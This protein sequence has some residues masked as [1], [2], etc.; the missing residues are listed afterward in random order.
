[1]SSPSLSDKIV[2]IHG[3][4]KDQLD[5]IFSEESKI[6]VTA[7]AGCGKTKSMVSKI[8][9]EIVNSKGK[10]FKRILALTF[11]VNAAI[12][13][14]DDTS[15]ILPDLLGNNDFNLNRKLDISNYHGFAKKLIN[16]HGYV[17]SEYLKT[18]DEFEIVDDTFSG[19]SSFMIDSEIREIQLLK[20][21]LIQANYA[22][23]DKGIGRYFE[24]TMEKLVSKKVI[25]YD[26]MLVI[27]I[28]LL[29]IDTIKSFYSKYY[30]M[31]IVDEFQDTNYLSYK[32]IV[33]L[34]GDSSKVILM[35]DDIQKIY[36]FIGAMP[37]AF[38]KINKE[39]NMT[40]LEFITNYRFKDNDSMK[41]LD[42]YLRGIFR[43]YE[44]L[45]NGY[46]EHAKLNFGF[47]EKAIGEVTKIVNMIEANLEND[48]T[49][50]VLVRAGWL[51]DG[52]GNELSNRG[53][54]YF[55]GLF[56][57]TD[58]V[59]KRFHELA[60]KYFI[61][62]S[63]TSKSLAK[64]VFDNIIANLVKNQ[65]KITDDDIIFKSLLRLLKALF[66]SVT[67]RPL[68]RQD[69]YLY[70]HFNLSSYSLKRLMNEIDDKVF[71][72]TIHGSKGLEWDYVYIPEIM[73][74]QFPT[75]RGLCNGCA[76]KRAGI[77]NKNYCVF[78]YPNNLKEPFLEELSLMY[79]AITRAKKD[80][81]A[82]ANV[83]QKRG[84]DKRRSCLTCLPNLE[85]IKI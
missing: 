76:S 28:K 33:S 9:Y 40:K 83:E 85:L 58:P 55:Y 17:L 69:K 18:V 64:R 50:A 45:S 70:I 61:K 5:F 67:K 57:D 19:L 65:K 74:Y 31:I 3:E 34:F 32:L 47:Y 2:S 51:A 53:I 14:K 37:D 16:Q 46:S 25:T 52:V 63:G 44:D 75:S 6:I 84:I 82:F 66:D 79:V 41:E 30:Q 21:N 11:S 13:I 20:S 59:Y 38:D 4:D 60:L 62:E 7:P 39:Y 35:G 15:E 22:E 77:K 78:T 49:S 10:N 71:L 27:A 43:N 1:M 72:T 12:K 42:K 36:S 56:A 68:S 81:Y 80:V 54:G 26:A 8:A 24:L 48:N 23:V 73:D 29:E